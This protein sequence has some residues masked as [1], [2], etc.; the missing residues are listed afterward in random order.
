MHHDGPIKDQMM[1]I[2]EDRGPHDVGSC[3]L[4]A[5]D[6]DTSESSDLHRTG[7][8]RQDRGI[9]A[10]DHCTITVIDRSSPNRMADN[11]HI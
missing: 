3:P 6:V 4:F 1:E 9:V 7:E 10:H 5:S 2:K 8:R 11:M